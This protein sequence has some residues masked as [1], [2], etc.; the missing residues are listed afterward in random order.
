[1]PYMNSLFTGPYHSVFCHIITY[2]RQIYLVE[3]DHSNKNNKNIL[4]LKRPKSYYS[5][6]ERVALVVFWSQS[7]NTGNPQKLRAGLFRGHVITYSISLILYC[8]YYLYYLYYTAKQYS[9]IPLTKPYHHTF[10]GPHY[11]ILPYNPR[12]IL[13]K[14]TKLP[15]HTL[16]DQASLILFQY[17]L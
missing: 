11:N 15:F 6:V 2:N 8:L 10:Q 5:L 12:S 7:G 14:V 13:Y 3:R 4:F 17:N 1:M 16:P 9:K